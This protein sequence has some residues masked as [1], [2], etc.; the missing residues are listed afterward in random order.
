LT[1]RSVGYF[2]VDRRNDTVFVDVLH[3]LLLE[4]QYPFGHPSRILIPGDGLTVLIDRES[5]RFNGLTPTC[6]N[7]FVLYSISAMCNKQSMP[8]YTLLIKK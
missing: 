1:S 7:N 4:F 2:F 6:Q 3:R 8:L 5:K